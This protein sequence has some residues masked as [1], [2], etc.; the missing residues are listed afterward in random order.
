MYC[1]RPPPLSDPSGLLWHTGQGLVWS[2]VMRYV[3]S[4]AGSHAGR[5]ITQQECLALYLISRGFAGM[6]G[7]PG[8]EPHNEPLDSP[9][10]NE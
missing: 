4:A 7:G 5:G 2:P 3:Q 1:T 6:M 8:A 9:V 10:Q